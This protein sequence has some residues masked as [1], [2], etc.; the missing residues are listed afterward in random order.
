[1]FYNKL[2]GFCFTEFLRCRNAT[3]AVVVVVVVVVVVSAVAVSAAV[4]AA[5]AFQ[6]KLCCFC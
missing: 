5:V 3:V 1:M 4:A 2:S 6:V